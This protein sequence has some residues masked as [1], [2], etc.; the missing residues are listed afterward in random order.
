M[1]VGGY[2]TFEQWDLTN[3]FV[4]IKH[5]IIELIVKQNRE[6]VKHLCGSE[7]NK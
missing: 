5:Y 4:N 3:K 2:T 7:I 1:I 6:N